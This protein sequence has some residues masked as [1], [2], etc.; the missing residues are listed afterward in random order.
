[1]AFEELNENTEKFRQDAESFLKN[2][3]AYHKLKVFKL[4]MLSI[5]LI[6]KI[7]LVG[8][9][10]SVFLLFCSL[11]AAFAIGEA[12]NSISLG[13]LI[14]GGIYLFFTLIIYFFRKKL[15]ESIILKKFSKIFF[16]H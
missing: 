9:G 16:N 2:T 10:L 6:S 3:L 4:T 14:L 1:M 11:A 7:L 5:T 13:F 12:L 8:L 15:V